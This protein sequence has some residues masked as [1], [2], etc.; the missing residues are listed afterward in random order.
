MGRMQVAASIGMQILEII[1]RG[2]VFIQFAVNQVHFLPQDKGTGVLRVIYDD[3]VNANKVTFTT[4]K[5][6]DLC[7]H[8]IAME[9]NINM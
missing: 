2:L 7:N 5:K 3:D 4:D 1:D 8:L 9:S 6:E